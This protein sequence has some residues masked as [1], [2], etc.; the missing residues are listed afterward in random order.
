MD[1]HIAIKIGTEFEAISLLWIIY[2]H[3]HRISHI[4]NVWCWWILNK[5]FYQGSGRTFKVSP[6]W[7]CSEPFFVALSSSWVAQSLC[8]LWHANV[9]VTS[10]W[11]AANT[12]HSEVKVCT[13][14]SKRPCAV[15]SV[16]HCAHNLSHLRKQSRFIKGTAGNYMWAECWAVLLTSGT[17]HCREA[18][19]CGVGHRL[20]ALIEQAQETPRSG[21]GATEGAE[22]EA[23][24]LEKCFKRHADKNQGSCVLKLRCGIKT[25]L[26]YLESSFLQGEK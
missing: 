3:K 22:N 9:P 26:D 21:W 25:M 15:A 14:S 23:S 20:R 19:G 10:T 13:V 6:I 24:I 16:C 12:D 18:R 8:R 7:N 5:G 1:G 17:R 11:P 4:I 2:P